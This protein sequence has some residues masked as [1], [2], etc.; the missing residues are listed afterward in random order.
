MKFDHKLTAMKKLKPSETY[1]FI[2]LLAL[3]IRLFYLHNI[4]ASPFFNHPVINEAEYDLWSKEILNGELLWKAVPYHGPVYPYTLALIYKFAGHNYYIGRFFG[5]LISSLA[6][7]LLAHISMRPFGKKVGVL[8]GVLAACYWPFIYW[9]CELL[10]AALVLFLNLAAFG[11]LQKARKNPRLIYFLSSGL[12]IGIS[13]ATR[14]NILLVLPFLLIW[15]WVGISRLP[16][17]IPKPPGLEP[18]DEGKVHGSERKTLLFRTR[19]ER[20]TRFIKTASVLMLG[21]LVIVVPV[22]FM[23]YKASGD[24]VFL[25]TQAELNLYLGLNPNLDSLHS[26]RPGIAW[27]KLMLEPIRLNLLSPAEK[28][29]YW[30][31]RSMEAVGNE[32]LL[33]IKHIFR[34]IFFI[35]SPNE[36]SSG[37]Y[38]F[39]NRNFAPLIFSLPGFWLVGPLGICGAMMGVKRRRELGLFYVFLIGIFVA[40]LPFQTCSR[41]RLALV[42]FLMVF[43]SYAIVEFGKRITAKDKKQVA[44]F[45]AMLIPGII[46]VNAD[47]AAT[48]YRDHSR[49]NLTLS[50]VYLRMS[51]YPRAMGEIRKSLSLRPN[52]ADSYNTLGDIYFNMGKLDKA[53]EAYKKALRLEPEY[54][55]AANAIGVINAMQGN[56]EVAKRYFKRALI[57]YPFYGNA[58]QNLERCDDARKKRP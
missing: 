40:S 52:E 5:V 55:R 29:K 1:L 57:I 25:Q 6:C 51:D 48:K 37:R 12:I 22:M 14:P 10:P 53:E 49:I 2:F 17:S 54:F 58:R 3:A 9:S 11:I 8:T 16:L 30:I 27:D 13:S 18:W 46:L 43:A 23:H 35:L 47:L 32:P 38:I 41:Y 4:M 24:F 44:L 33:F 39:Y 36:I 28:S 7:I 56:Y 15:L 50:Q 34:K 31:A 26:I 19:I 21:I 42:P 45:I 20:G